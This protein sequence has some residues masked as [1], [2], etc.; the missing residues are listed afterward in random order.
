[1]E[2]LMYQFLYFPEDKSAYIPAAFEFLI[3]LILCIG[4]FMIF[5][6]I[7]KKQELKSKEIEAR[8]LAERNSANNR[9]N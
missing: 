2:H 1:M 6:K 8:I 9:H 5:R 3:M 4:V 7:S